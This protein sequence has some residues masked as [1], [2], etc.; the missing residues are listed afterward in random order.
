L[1][2]PVSITRNKLGNLVS[3]TE[4]SKVAYTQELGKTSFLNFL[5]QKFDSL[6]ILLQALPFCQ[7]LKS[8]GK[9]E[10]TSG[11]SV[12]STSKGKKV[13]KITRRKGRGDGKLSWFRFDCAQQ[14]EKVG[15]DV[16]G[17]GN[18]YGR[19]LI[20]KAYI[21]TLIPALAITQAFK[22]S[23]PLL[24]LHSSDCS[25][26]KIK[27]VLS[28]PIL[29]RIKTLMCNKQGSWRKELRCSCKNRSNSQ[30]LSN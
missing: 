23:A 13:D 21:W 28:R 7:K 27:H 26:E 25:E 12:S 19:H 10:Q 14:S 9:H 22:F 1:G 5:T 15:L 8:I 16:I 17:L 2:N 18:L 30:T 4:D 6:R 3:F 24:R 20:L 29:I 11:D